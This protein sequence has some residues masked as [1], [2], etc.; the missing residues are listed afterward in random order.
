MA[1]GAENRSGVRGR[2]GRRP[3]ND[4][5]PD[6]SREAK[7]A[8]PKWMQ[9]RVRLVNYPQNQ[10]TIHPITYQITLHH[11]DRNEMAVG[12]SNVEGV[13]DINWVERLETII[14]E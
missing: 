4:T 12:S 9:E 10:S 1:Q 11:Y 5:Q 3:T 2:H 7:I 6:L 13:E 8:I 14:E